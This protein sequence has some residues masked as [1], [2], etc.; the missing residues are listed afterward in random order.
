MVKQYSLRFQAYLRLGL[1]LGALLLI[2]VLASFQNWRLD[3]TA[4][5]RYSLHPNTRALMAGLKDV[6]FVRVYLEGDFP[7]GFRKLRNTTEDLLRQMR[8]ESGGKLEYEF[9]DPSAQ[10]DRK[11]TNE[12]FEQLYKQGLQPTD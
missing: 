6:V 7:P 8:R 4:E 9:T 3:L 1:V 5:Q 2:N 11:S 12:L 10:P